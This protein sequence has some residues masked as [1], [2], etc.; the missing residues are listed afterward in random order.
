MT[1][2][3]D[4][5]A[6]GLSD[7]LGIPGASAVS[8]LDPDGPRV[9]WWAGGG[10]PDEQ[11]AA[12]VVTLA[13]AAAGMVM[14]GE[15]GDEFGD[16]LLT[17]SDAFHVVRLVEDDTSPLVAHLTLRRA[18]ANLA[19]ARRE[20]GS[21]IKAYAGKADQ[22]RKAAAPALTSPPAPAIAASEVAASAP[23]PTS[24]S[25]SASVPEEIAAAVLAA[26]VAASAEV[27]APGELASSEPEPSPPP[28]ELPRRN[29]VEPSHTDDSPDLFS[30]LGQPYAADD[31]I[32]DRVLDALRAL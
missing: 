21:L 12:T 10:P 1:G 27:D 7:A 15:T 14:L 31:A 16:V 19:M 17:S 22:T 28:G 23:A 13:A 3:T 6:P 5:G 4:P 9:L 20:F 26:G 29:R 18:G 24:G 8:L 30:L 32:L 11:Q 25:V 2:P